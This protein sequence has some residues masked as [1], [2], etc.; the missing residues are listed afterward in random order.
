MDYSVD[1]MLTHDIDWFC[2][3]NGIF[4]HLASAGGILP[5]SFRDRDALRQLQH[6][7]AVA[8]YLFE[9]EDVVDN[10]E[11][12]NQRFA[13]NPKGRTSYV[14]S[15]RDMARK[16]FVSMDRTFLTNP[17][18]THYHIVCWPRG[19]NELRIENL[20]IPTMPIGE[21]PLLNFRPLGL[22]DNNM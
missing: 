13:D 20:E 1:Y 16:G 18:D 22:L 8:P 15:F 6:N 14:V 2:I 17:G 3:V 11:F 10:E 19:W 5:P 4:V 21:M 7:V 12:L 9:E